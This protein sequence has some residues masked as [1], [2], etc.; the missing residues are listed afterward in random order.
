VALL[1]SREQL[2]VPVLSVIPEHPLVVVL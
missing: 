2:A 1:I